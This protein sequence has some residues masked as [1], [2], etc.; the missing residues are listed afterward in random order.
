[1]NYSGGDVLN[2]NYGVVVG[3]WSGRY[4]NGKHPSAWTGSV[5]ILRQ[6]VSTKKPVKYGQCWVFAG[7]LTTGQSLFLF[8]CLF[9]CLFVLFFVVFVCVC[10]TVVGF[11]CCCHIKVQIHCKLT[12]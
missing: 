2:P 9:V 10:F 12:A 6:F 8:V 7:V 5:K 4:K 1:M 3:N 11:S